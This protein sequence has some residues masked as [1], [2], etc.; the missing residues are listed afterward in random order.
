MDATEIHAVHSMLH[1]V[2]HRNKNQH[3]RAKWWKW[4]SLLKHTTLDLAQSLD[5]A[6]LNVAE[7][8]RQHLVTH[9]IPRCYLAFTTVVADNQFSALGIV[10]MATL[11]RIVKAA[12]I[13]LG[14]PTATRTKKSL[15]K[16]TT[17]TPV[18]DLGEQMRRGD[19][20]QGQAT[21]RA[22]SDPRVDGQRQSAES[23][24]GPTKRTT[25]TKT[26]TKK[27]KNAID[28]LFSGLL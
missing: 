1:L 23:T 20:N 24:D 13:N 2:F 27:R 12:G 16:T 7:S 3:Q 8:H 11:A 14:R 9:L 28:D 4:L 26:K 17:I 18:E 19:D 15:Q 5:G 25:K 22:P 6:R 10:L 21:G